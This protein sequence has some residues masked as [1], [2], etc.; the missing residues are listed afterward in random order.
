MDWSDVNAF[1]IKDVP[2]VDNGDQPMNEDAPV[3]LSDID[4]HVPPIGKASDQKLF[5]G[6]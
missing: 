4:A 2:D 1:H 6:V 3:P 5:R